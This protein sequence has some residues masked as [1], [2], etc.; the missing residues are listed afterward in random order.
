MINASINT[1]AKI[2]VKSL[3]IG[4]VSKRS[5]GLDAVDN[6][7]DLDKPISTAQ[8]TE[9][10]IV[11]SLNVG[12]L[13]FLNDGTTLGS[14]A[15]GQLD[16]GAVPDNAVRADIGHAVT[17]LGNSAFNAALGSGPSLNILTEVT[18]PTSVTEIQNSVFAYQKLTNIDIPNSVTSIGSQSFRANLLESLSISGSVTSIGNSAFKDNLL[19][20]VTFPDDATAGLTIEG[21]AFENNLITELNIGTSVNIIGASAFRDNDFTSID[22]PSTVTSIGTSAFAVNTN[23]NTVTAFCPISAFSGTSI[24]AN[25]VSALTIYVDVDDNSWDSLEALNPSLYQGIPAVTIQ[26]IAVT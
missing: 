18:I 12:T 7:S 24:F 11:K 6:T 26:R 15:S 21:S 14:F 13:F 8:Q 22:I 4:D 17:I 19:T 3:V 23:L 25:T 1:P 16:P 9:I 2:S 10:A 20:A 5:L